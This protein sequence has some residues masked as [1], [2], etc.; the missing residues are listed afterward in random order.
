[1][2]RFDVKNWSWDNGIL[3]MVYRFLIVGL[4]LGSFFPT[5]AATPAT[6]PADVAIRIVGIDGKPAAGVLV[7]FVPAG[8]VVD[9]LSRHEVDDD[10]NYVRKHTDSEGRV[11]FALPAGP[12]MVIVADDSGCARASGEDLRR[13]AVIHLRAWGKLRGQFMIGERPGAGVELMVTVNEDSAEA[14]MP[15]IRVHGQNEGESGY[16]K[17]DSEGRFTIEALPPGEL[18][19]GRHLT[20]RY[21]GDGGAGGIDRERPVNVKSG[22]VT[23][24]RLGGDGRVVVGK[25]MLSPTLGDRAQLELGFCHAAHKQKPLAPP[26]PAEIMGASLERQ[27]AWYAEFIKTDAGRAYQREKERVSALSCQ[28]QPVLAK[29]DSFRIDDVLPGHY[30]LSAGAWRKKADGKT[31]DYVGEVKLEFDVPA[32]GAGVVD[33]GAIEVKAPPTDL[34]A[35]DVAPEFTLKSLDGEMVR[36]SDYRGKYVL[37]DFWATW[38]GP[39]VAEMPNLKKLH[40]STRGDGRFVMISISVD[41]DPFIPKRFVVEHGDDWLQT[42]GGHWSESKVS[43]DYNIGGIPSIWLISPEGKIVAKGLRGDEIEKV[44]SEALKK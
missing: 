3:I 2:S 13:D 32:D 19:V 27:Q 39:C 22:E 9:I 38:C 36:L 28:C 17:T 15:G 42:F 31:Y 1:L 5:F 26:V 14:G 37:I 16:I 20:W 43:Q 44:V 41:D 7:V 24:V 8:R 21:A 4:M 12:S 29:D 25:F 35:G 23:T 11:S 18:Y 6:Q 30:T 34:S 40:E 10:S 33:I